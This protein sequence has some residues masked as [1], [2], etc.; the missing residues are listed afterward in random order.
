M[1]RQWDKAI[2]DSTQAIRIESGRDEAFF[3][4]ARARA[5]SGDLDSAISDYDE[6]IRRVPDDSDAYILRASLGF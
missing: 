4:R 5:L 6:V 2:S 1:K 3:V